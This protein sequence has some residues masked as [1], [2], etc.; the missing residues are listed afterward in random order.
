MLDWTRTM[1]KKNRRILYPFDEFRPF[2]SLE[3]RFLG[4]VQ[5]FGDLGVYIV[6][7]TAVQGV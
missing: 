1:C 4:I 6:F 3:D 5:H 7:L 2:N